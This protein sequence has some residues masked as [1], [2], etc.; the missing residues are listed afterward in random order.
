MGQGANALLI[1]PTQN[2]APPPPTPRPHP[3][4]VNV[5]QNARKVGTS[6]ETA[7]TTSVRGATA[8]ALG[9]PCP[10]ALR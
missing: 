5:A 8:G 6:I 9:I 7:L 2:I 3:P 10:T 1:N 4:P